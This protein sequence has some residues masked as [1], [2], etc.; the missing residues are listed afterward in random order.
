M[1]VIYGAA[2]PLILS[3]HLDINT[4]RFQGEAYVE[5]LMYG[6]ALEMREKGELQD[7]YFE[8]V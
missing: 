2:T 4:F 5:G 3:P 8:I 7:T 1:S 6:E